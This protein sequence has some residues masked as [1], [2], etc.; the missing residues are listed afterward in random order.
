MRPKY[1]L[2]I[3]IL[4]S[5]FRVSPCVLSHFFCMYILYI[6]QIMTMTIDVSQISIQVPNM[7]YVH[8]I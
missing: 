6:K 8:C 1:F 4:T 2:A 5:F 7:Y 3:E